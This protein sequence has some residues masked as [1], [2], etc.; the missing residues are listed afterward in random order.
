M[1]GPASSA[2]RRSPRPQTCTPETARVAASAVESRSIATSRR[3]TVSVTG[4]RPSV[5][6][7]AI[8]RSPS[9]VRTSAFVLASRAAC[10]LLKA[11]ISGTLS[12]S[13][14]RLS[15]MREIPRDQKPIVIEFN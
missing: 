11:C 2:T 3:N 6:R 12:R 1:F 10:A 7:P 15:T 14:R 9:A 13:L 5:R 8:T 4:D